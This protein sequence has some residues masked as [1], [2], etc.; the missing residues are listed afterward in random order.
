MKR[1]TILEN[2]QW[3]TV[4]FHA[5]FLAKSNREF[6]TIRHFGCYDLLI[7]ITEPGLSLS[8]YRERSEQT[9]DRPIRRGRLGAC[10]ACFGNRP[11]GARCATRQDVPDGDACD[12]Q[13]GPHACA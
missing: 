3:K 5:K 12:L 8:S 2:R 6:M 1:E 10:S 9:N 4:T 7:E 13:R 11:C